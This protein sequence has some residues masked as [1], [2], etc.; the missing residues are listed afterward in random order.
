MSFVSE[1]PNDAAVEYIDYEHSHELVEAY[2]CCTV[3]EYPSKDYLNF[4]LGSSREKI[5]EHPLAL[6]VLQHP[7]SV[8]VIRTEYPYQLV[9]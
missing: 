2:R 4:S 3:G 7:V 6:R 9:P 5:S 1:V 8:K